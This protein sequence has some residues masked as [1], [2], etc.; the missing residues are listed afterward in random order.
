MTAP[1]V[2]TTTCSPRCRSAISS[3]ASHPGDDLGAGLRPR[4]AHRQIARRPRVEHVLTDP[5]PRGQPRAVAHPDVVES[6]QRPRWHAQAGAHYLGRLDRAP[7][8]GAACRCH[9]LRL[10]PPGERGRLLPADIAQGATGVATPTGPGGIR[11]LAGDAPRR[12]ER[13][14]ADSPVQYPP[15]R[16]QVTGQNGPTHR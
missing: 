1:W 4:H 14:S 12:G 15:R 16:T 2:T 6:G 11:R 9:P 13:G 5:I 3:S 7:Q 10:Q 8:G